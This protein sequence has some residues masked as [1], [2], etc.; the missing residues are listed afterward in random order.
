MTIPQASTE[1]AELMGFIHQM[2][3][4]FDAG[5]F[6]DWREFA[7]PV[8]E[9]YT[10]ERLQTIDDVVMGWEKMASHL[11]QQTLIH[12]TAALVGL[13]GLPEYQALSDDDKN[14]AMWIV[15]YH[16]VAK[17]PLPDK[18]DST[19]GFRSAATCG[20]GIMGAEWV[21]PVEPLRLYM[22]HGT[23][24]NARVYSNKERDYVQDN[25]RLPEIMDGIDELFGGRDSPAGLIICGILFHMSLNVVDAWP[26]ANPLTDGQ[27]KA[28]ITP[29]LL[30]LLKTMMLSDNRAWGLFRPELQQSETEQLYREFKRV[31]KLIG[32]I[33]P[34]PPQ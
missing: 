22:W 6:Q 9:W 2:K 21:D 14:L 25:H 20:A 3:A 1:L 29:R 30:P 12:V 23:L 16:D 13:L 19:H 15:L 18:R 7:E 28:C 11:N 4:D 26:Q 32:A 24:T 17:V 10:E 33:E 8:R 31:A 5:K 34:K 27:I